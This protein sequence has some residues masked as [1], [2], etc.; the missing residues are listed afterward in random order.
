M[1]RIAGNR[2]S[3]AA[4]T[5]ITETMIPSDI[6]RKAGLGTSITA[7]SET[8][9]VRPEKRTALPA[10]SIVSPTASTGSSP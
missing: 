5:K 6:E 1:A 4:S 9:T 3:V 10:V 7:E 8:S 2:V